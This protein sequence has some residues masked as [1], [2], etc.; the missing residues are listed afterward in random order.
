[1]PVPERPPFPPV[2]TVYLLHFEKP[3]KHARH[4]LG[5]TVDIDRRMKSHATGNGARLMEVITQNRIPWHVART[6]TGGKELEQAL[7]T[8]HNGSRH[9]FTCMQ[10]R[11]YART[12]SVK[13]SPYPTRRRR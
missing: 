7:K 8:W 3:Y 4:Y 6:W 11:I 5:W 2:G 12:F 1:M 9:C 13:A 10:E